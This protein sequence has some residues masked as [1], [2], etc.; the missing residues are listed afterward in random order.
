M[1]AIGSGEVRKERG[2][3]CLLSR[4]L[5]E[6]R[7]HDLTPTPPPNS[8]IITNTSLRRSERAFIVLSVN[9]E[10][11]DG[12]RLPWRRAAD[13]HGLNGSPA[14]LFVGEDTCVGGRE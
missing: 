10:Q 4:L 9:E 2:L 14:N 7:A 8:S 5:V 12:R 1:S 3:L 11:L 13:M 6:D